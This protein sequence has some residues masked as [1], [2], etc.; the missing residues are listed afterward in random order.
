MRDIFK[1]NTFGTMAMIQALLPQFREK[2]GR[3]D[4]QRHLQRHAE[5]AAAAVGLYRQQGRR[6]R[7]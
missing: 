5:T 6:E 2:T 4:H 3:G 7:V 1:A